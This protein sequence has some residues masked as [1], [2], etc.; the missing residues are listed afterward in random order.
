MTEPLNTTAA[1]DPFIL[2]LRLDDD[3]FAFL[4]G[5]RRQYFPPERN[6][7]AAHV[8]LFH[9]LPGDAASVT[10]IRETLDAVCATTARFDLELPGLRSLGRGVAV[11]I[12]SPAL[13]QLHRRLVEAF[14]AWLSAQDRQ[15]FQPHVTIQNKV[16]PEEARELLA[17][18]SAGWESVTAY[19]NGLSLWRYRGGPWEGAGTF[20]FGKGDENISE[21][22]S[23]TDFAAPVTLRE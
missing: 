20:L 17:N 19:A 23:Q 18:L 3:S 11:E 15:K 16:P 22:A 9:A 12:S 4:D 8:T 1:P 5:L 7:I 13:L 14:E 6:F 2:S 21:T 10:V